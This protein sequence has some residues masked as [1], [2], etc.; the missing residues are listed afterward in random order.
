TTKMAKLAVLITL[1][2]IL[3]PVAC[4]DASVCFNG[5]LRVL[6][7]ASCPRGSRNNFFTR[8]RRP[9]PSGPGLS[10]GYYNNRG[11]FCPRAEGIVRNAVKAAT[12]Q[13]PGIGAGLIRLFFHDCFVRVR[14]AP[15][16][17][18]ITPHEIIKSTESVAKES[19]GE[20]YNHGQHAKLDKHTATLP[21]A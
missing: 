17:S 16:L 19:F 10:Y 7:P 12:D 1:L 2:A 14:T 4:Q 8:Q 21:I 13:N 15:F 6:N 11:S 18:L 20:Y 3:G 9:A 5:W